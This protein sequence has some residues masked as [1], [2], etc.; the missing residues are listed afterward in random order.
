[1]QDDGSTI[2][3]GLPELRVIRVAEGDQEVVVAVA[4]RARSA[5]CPACGQ[6]AWRVHSTRQQG[7]RDRRLRDKAV[8]LLLYKRRFRCGAC[9]K[10]FSAPDPLCGLRRR[11]TQ[12]FRLPVGQ[13]RGLREALYQTIRHLAQ[14]EEVGEALVRPALRGGR[15]SAVGGSFR[16]PCGLRAGAG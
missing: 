5:P 6:E 2:R 10:V 8:F 7:K 15:G 3:L 13:P 11:S 1:M 14:R 12:R 9:G 4:S 16:P